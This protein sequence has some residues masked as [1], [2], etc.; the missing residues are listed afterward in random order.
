MAQASE[1]EHGGRLLK[2]EGH[3][4]KTEG[5]LDNI[6]R[7]QVD[8]G[9]KLD[10]VSGQLSDI[11]SGLATLRSAPRFDLHAWVKT[12]GVLFGM[13]S[14]LGGLATWFVVAMTQ[15]SVQTQA[16]ELKHLREITELRFENMRMGISVHEKTTR[17]ITQ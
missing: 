14:I 17:G 9:M 12:L 7:T 8:H 11:I 10:R 13:L 1:H 6:E 15:V 16:L 5:R 3:A 2:L 4:I